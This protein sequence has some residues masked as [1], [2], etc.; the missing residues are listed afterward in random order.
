MNSHWSIDS[1]TVFP[2]ARLSLRLLASKR[3]LLYLGVYILL[4]WLCGY[5]TLGAL[6]RLVFIIMLGLLITAA[7]RQV[8]QPRASNLDTSDIVIP[9]TPVQD[10]KK[11]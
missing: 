5:S 6:I 10:K 9:S 1:N 3:T 7:I 8:T 4:M 11:E 2:L